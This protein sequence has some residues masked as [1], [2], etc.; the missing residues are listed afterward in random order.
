ARQR[1]IG[2][3]GARVNL[4]CTDLTQAI[5]RAAGRDIPLAQSI[6]APTRQ[7]PVRFY[8]AGMTDVNLAACRHCGERAAR[9]RC[10][11]LAVISPAPKCTVGA[12]RATGVSPHA[13]L[14]ERA[15][16]RV[17]LPSIVISPARDAAI[18]VEAAGKIL[19]T[20]DLL[21]SARRE[22]SLAA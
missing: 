19:S 13:Q 8:T 2:L 12:E 17:A 4:A 1:A 16:R 14:G 20:V 3:D 9:R 5:G 21:E 18:G 6:V 7:G 22:C 15:A 10:L 11:S